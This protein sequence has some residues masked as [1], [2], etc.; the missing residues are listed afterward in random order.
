MNY[1]IQGDPVRA[2]KIKAAFERLGINVLDFGFADK[3]VVYCSIGG[4]GGCVQYIP[5]SINLMHI[6]HSHPGYKEL[7]LELTVKP[8]K[9]K[10]G[11]WLWHKE[12][13]VF[14]VLIAGYDEER[15]Y[16]A[17]YIGSESYFGRD[18]T[19][20]EYRLWS[21]ADAKDGD[22][23]ATGNII[24]IFKKLD[25]DGYYIISPCIYTVKDGLEVI[26]DEDDTIGSCGFKPAT[27]E[28]RELLFRKMKEAGY[29]WDADKKELRKIQHYDIANFHEGMP[30]L[31]RDDNSDE[32]N[33]LLFSH[34][35]KKF[36]DHFF[37][38]GSPWCQC[39]PYENNEH[40]LGTTD[41][42]D[43]RYINW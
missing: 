36:S 29:E 18:A 41:P 14:P 4:C 2:D 26:D 38:G 17:K 15:G 9:F 24:C 19:E 35:R 22:V 8:T 10:A 40:L 30:V 32:W 1:Y 33:Y 6:L 28:D 13:G 5:Y 3:T 16:L 31:V 12:K 7:E 42:C 34:Y 25:K 23:L 39:I 20:N 43:E 11:D 27:K 21:I 37:A